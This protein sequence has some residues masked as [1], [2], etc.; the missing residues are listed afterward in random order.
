LEMSRARDHYKPCWYLPAWYGNTTSDQMRLEQYLSFQTN[1]QGMITPPDCEPA[2]NAGPRQGIVESNQL[3]KRLGPIFTTMPVTRPPVAMLYSLS[4][5]IHTQTQDRSRTYA[6]EM[7]QGKNLPLT[8]LAGKLLR[9]QFMTVV[10]EDVLDGTLA[11]EHKAIIL[12]SL[13]YLDPQVIAALESFAEGGG[14]VLLT[15]DCTVKIKGAVTLPVKPAMP[16]QLKID[17][18]TAAKKYDQLR[19]D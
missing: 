15:G 13:D 1:I 3:M 6:H 11:S 18:L 16:D 8:Y 14:L 12:T 9:Q 7:P 5:N 4:Q 2:T 10:E 19:P 17:E